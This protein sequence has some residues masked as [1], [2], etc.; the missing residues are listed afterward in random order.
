MATTQGDV[1]LLNDPVAKEL[2]QSTIPARFAYNALD[3][4]PRVVPICFHWNGREIVLG[5]PLA[6]PKVPW[7]QANRPKI[8]GIQRSVM[9]PWE[10]YRR[11]YVKLSR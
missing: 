4:T 7:L 2:L 6:A 5:T 9:R 11:T 3:G 1:A 10:L 8:T